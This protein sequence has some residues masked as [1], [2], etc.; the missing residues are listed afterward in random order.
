MDSPDTKLQTSV[1]PQ[2]IL[3]D[4]TCLKDFLLLSIHHK[5]V[6]NKVPEEYM[7]SFINKTDETISNSF[8]EINTIKPF[9]DFLNF[10]VSERHLDPKEDF[11]VI[12]YLHKP[13]LEDSPES[14]KFF[15]HV[16]LSKKLKTHKNLK[17]RL[18][19]NFRTPEES[20]I[21]I[22]IA[23]NSPLKPFKLLKGSGNWY[24]FDSTKKDKHNLEILKESVL[25]ETQF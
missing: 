22:S 3:D 7:L 5:L 19:F 6:E 15:C 23:E 8:F 1:T 14:L 10:L 24:R 9:T 13:P 11:E 25:E 12:Y 20:F 2:G 18:L 16:S 17:L 4:Y 21:R